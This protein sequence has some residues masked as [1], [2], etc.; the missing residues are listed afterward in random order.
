MDLYIL[1]NNQFT[2]QIHNI[3]IIAQKNHQHMICVVHPN[4]ELRPLVASSSLL[5]FNILH[6]Y[7]PM[8]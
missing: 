3:N 4:V 1:Y 2:K 8:R 5:G 7:A 6:S